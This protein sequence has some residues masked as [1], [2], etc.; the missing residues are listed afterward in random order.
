MV[1]RFVRLEANYGDSA[2]NLIG[3]IQILLHCRRNTRR[4]LPG[5]IRVGLPGFTGSADN[6]SAPVLQRRRT[7]SIGCFSERRNNR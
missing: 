6:L 7:I 1:S 3:V 5:A 2:L 4:F